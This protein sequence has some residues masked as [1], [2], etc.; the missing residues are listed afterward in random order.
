HQHFHAATAV[1]QQDQGRG[2]NRRR[3]PL[4]IHV[5]GF[6]QV[7]IGVEFLA[8]VHPG[9][10]SSS[11]RAQGQGSMRA[12]ALPSI[13]VCPLWFTLTT[14]SWTKCWPSMLSMAVTVAVAVRSAPG[15]TWRGKR[16]LYSVRRPSPTQLVSITPVA[17]IDSMPWANTPG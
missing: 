6:Q 4:G 5:I 2:R 14:S 12:V 16:A 8:V 7:C 15:Q 10:S 9:L 3:Y 11:G 13:T 1:A 17:P